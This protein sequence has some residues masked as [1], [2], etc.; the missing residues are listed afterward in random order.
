[1]SVDVAATLAEITS[2]PV[3]ERLSIVEAIWDSIEADEVSLPLSDEHRE[4]LDR[5]LAAYAANPSAVVSWETV[6]AAALARARG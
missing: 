5:R 2:L 6:L 4:E 3:E 1:V